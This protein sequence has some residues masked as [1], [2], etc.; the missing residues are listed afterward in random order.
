MR[1]IGRLAWAVLVAAVALALAGCQEDGGSATGSP[2][3]TGSTGNTVPTGTTGTSGPTG[4]TEASGPSGETGA[5]EGDGDVGF[6][7]GS[8]ACELLTEELLQPIVGGADLELILDAILTED[9][10]RCGWEGVTEPL[11]VGLTLTEAPVGAEDFEVVQT[12]LEDV[13]GVE[14]IPGLGDQAIQHL[15]LYVLVDGAMIE[16]TVVDDGEQAPE[17]EQAVARAVVEAMASSG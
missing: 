2:G 14:E 5:T 7:T 4:A 9:R 16:V 1:V 10:S 12:G 15:N 13:E 11:I 17:L 6:P 3:G 8:R